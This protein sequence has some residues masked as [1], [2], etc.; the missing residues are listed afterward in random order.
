MSMKH[1][2]FNEIVY[3]CCIFAT[4]TT[5]H[6][7][8]TSRFKKE[9]LR[10]IFWKL[11]STVQVIGCFILQ[12]AGEKKLLLFYNLKRCRWNGKQFLPTCLSV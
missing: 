5:F 3:S 10:E 8:A 9:K 12:N 4:N 7:Y 2:E 1:K 11:E 6:L